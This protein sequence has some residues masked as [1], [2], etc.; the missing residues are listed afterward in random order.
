MKQKQEALKRLIDDFFKFQNSGKLDTSSEATA[1]SWLEE[2]LKIFRWDTRNPLEIDQEYTLDKKSKKNIK[3]ID[4]HH[5]RPD[6]V[7]KKGKQI[8][9]YL[10]AKRIRVDIESSK[11]S[12]FQI[13]G[14]G[15]SSGLPCSIVSDFEEFSIYDC[16]FKPSLTDDPSICRVHYIPYDKYIENFDLLYEHL[17]K[18]LIYSGHLDT[19]YPIDSPPRG[20]VTLDIDFTDKLR[21]A[22]KELAQVILRYN[23]DYI[24][25]NQ[26]LLS[27]IVQIILDRI[28]FL[29]VCEG[30]EIEPENRLL[31][32]TKDKD[33]SF[34]E[35]FKI[36]CK[37]NYSNHYDGPLFPKKNDII[38]NIEIK[39][40]Y[41]DK[42]IESLYYPFPYKFDVIPD[43]ST[44]F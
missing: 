2:L 18:D 3:N 14:Y 12:A 19:L 32:I 16:R 1:R 41:L 13:R 35:N 37:N 28:I 4:S 9:Q 31:E 23:K 26:N 7:F 5:T 42:F 15:W 39:G 29:R 17:S 44:L 38:E 21:Q 33:L 40:K 20:A 8:L 25:K 43:D 22:R 11:T 27:N 34:F 10:D 36:L 6:Y 30:K 24:D